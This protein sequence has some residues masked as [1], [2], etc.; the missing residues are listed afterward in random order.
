RSS[1]AMTAWCLYTPPPAPKRARADASRAR[2]EASGPLA[3]IPVLVNDTIDVAGLPTTAG[4]MA[5]EDVP[6]SADAALVTRRKAAGAIIL[7]KVNVSELN[8]MVS[9]GQPAGY[10]ALH[11]QGVNPYDMRSTVNGSSAGAVAAAASG[12][13]AATVGVETDASTN[14]TTNP[15]N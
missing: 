14:G 5:L 6:P 3:G 7:G 15:T 9:T 13:A 10:G 1:S 11:G 4:S 2:G 8:G 12:L